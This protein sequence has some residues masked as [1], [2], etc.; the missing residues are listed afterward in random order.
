VKDPYSFWSG[1]LI[2]LCGG[3]L[4][5]FGFYIDDTNLNVLAS[6]ESIGATLS[7]LGLFLAGLGF[8]RLVVGYFVLISPGK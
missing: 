7:F 8:L 1:V 3:V 2:A 4:I 6:K 5:Y